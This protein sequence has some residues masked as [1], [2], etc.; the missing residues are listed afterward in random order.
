MVNHTT[1]D[2]QSIVNWQF[3]VAVGSCAT[4]QAPQHVMHRTESRAVIARTGWDHRPEQF[5]GDSGGF[6]AGELAQLHHAS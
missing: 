6:G 2:Y 3:P 4:G 5:H 1:I